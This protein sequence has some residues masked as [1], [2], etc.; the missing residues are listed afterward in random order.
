M[1]YFNIIILTAF[2]ELQNGMNKTIGTLIY[3]FSGPD[4]TIKIFAKKRMRWS[5]YSSLRGRGRNVS[6]I[7]IVAK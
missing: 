4:K 7:Q 6:N 2:D 3:H 1:R 5:S